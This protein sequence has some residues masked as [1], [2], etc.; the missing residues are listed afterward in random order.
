ML[1]RVISCLAQKKLIKRVISGYSRESCYFGLFWVVLGYFGLFWVILGY[2]SRRSVYGLFWYFRVILVYPV[3]SAYSY[4][5]SYFNVFGSFWAIFGYISG[6][7]R[8]FPY[9]IFVSLT[10]LF[11]CFFVSSSS[12]SYKTCYFGLFTLLVLFLLILV[13]F[14]VFWLTLAYSRLFF[15]H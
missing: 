10:L 12:T 9:S 2:F 1:F 14:R 6:Y 7:F 4:K 15:L 8:S 5:S 11:S 13:C 3:I